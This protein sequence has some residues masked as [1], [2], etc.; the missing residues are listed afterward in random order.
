MIKLCAVACVLALTAC[1]ADVGS[2]PTTTSAASSSNDD[3]SEV[4]NPLIRTREL[5]EDEGGEM[6]G[7]EG[8]LSGSGPACLTI[9]ESIIVWPNAAEWSSEN[10]AVVNLAD[11]D[12][13]AQLGQEQNLGGVSSELPLSQLLED[14]LLPELTSRL[15]ECSAETGF[16]AVFIVS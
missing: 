6:E 5:S 10:S 12:Y 16:S 7:M 9:E 3:V 14:R 15:I 11:G 2:G 4:E 8:I 13:E 1:T